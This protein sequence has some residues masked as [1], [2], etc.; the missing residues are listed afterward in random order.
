MRGAQKLMDTQGLAAQQTYR[1][2][3]AVARARQSEL[4]RAL[5]SAASRAEADIIRAQI[6]N[7]RKA[8]AMAERIG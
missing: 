6:S 3:L 1:A 2:L 7:T 5:A 4:E 8:I